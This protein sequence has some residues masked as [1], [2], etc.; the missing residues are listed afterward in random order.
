MNTKGLS[1][2]FNYTHFVIKKNIEGT[3]HQGSLIC[4]SPGGNC[5]NWILGHI[6]ANRNTVLELLDRV[7][8]WDEQEAS[9]YERG[10][11]SLDPDHPGIKNLEE[12]VAALDRSQGEILSALEA[13]SDEQLAEK[14][15]D[16]SVGDLL[17]GLSFHEAYHAGQTGILRRLEGREGALK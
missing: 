1:V 5:L 2:Q 16:Q 15:G 7:P 13:M 17:F 12:I 6:V 10:Q 8:V 14:K 3:T 9:V 4:P 11:P